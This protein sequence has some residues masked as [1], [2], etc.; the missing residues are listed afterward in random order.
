MFAF[1]VCPLYDEC[2]HE[3]LYRTHKRAFLGYKPSIAVLVILHSLG[4]TAS[5][6]LDYHRGSSYQ[7]MLLC[8]AEAISY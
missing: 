6:I 4:A 1:T 3:Y 2:C 7:K 8:C 5:C